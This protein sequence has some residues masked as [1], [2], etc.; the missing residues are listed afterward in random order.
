MKVD[1]FEYKYSKISMRAFGKFVT[2]FKTMKMSYLIT[3][4][5]V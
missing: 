2:T 3:D 4:L 5:T 1:I